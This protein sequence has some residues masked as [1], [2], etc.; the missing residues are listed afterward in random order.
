MLIDIVATCRGVSPDSLADLEIVPLEFDHV[1]KAAL[2][3][4]LN[5]VD[6]FRLGTPASESGGA[7]ASSTEAPSVASHSS[8]VGSALPPPALP[9]LQ[10]LSDVALGDVPGSALAEERKHGFRRN[11]VP[12]HDH[13]VLDYENLYCRGKMNTLGM[14]RP[15]HRPY[16]CYADVQKA[17][18]LWKLNVLG[19]TFPYEHLLGR[20][21]PSFYHV[22]VVGGDAALHRVLCNFVVTR[23]L[24]ARKKAQRAAQA[25]PP[26]GEPVSGFEMRI[27]LVPAARGSAEAV[28]GQISDMASFIARHDVWYRRQVRV[29]R[30]M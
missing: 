9:V 4:V 27:F 23:Q 17:N 8:D 13:L 24:E 19:C 16:C 22:C 25:R 21:F 12:V 18:S 10:R 11:F 6:K 26:D 5:P 14:E 2:P 20:S 30:A 28:G 29:G 3:T 15:G 7:S 1:K